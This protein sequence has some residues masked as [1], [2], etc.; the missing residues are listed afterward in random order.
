MRESQIAIRQYLYAAIAHCITVEGTVG[1]MEH[2]SD[3]RA[4]SR[5]ARHPAPGSEEETAQAWIQELMGVGVIYSDVIDG[6][7]LCVNKF[8]E[9]IKHGHG[10]MLNA[11]S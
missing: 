8:W 4:L 11:V 9:Q 7:D 6:S 1:D 2:V 5:H 10:T 3:P